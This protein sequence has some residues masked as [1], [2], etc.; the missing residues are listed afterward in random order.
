[1]PPARQHRARLVRFAIVA[2]IMIAQTFDAALTL[3]RE[4]VA[5]F[6]QNE[7]HF[8]SPKYSEYDVRREFIDRFWQALGWDVLHRAQPIPLERD[9]QVET[10]VQVEGRGKRADYAF[11]APNFRDVLFFVEAKKPSRNIENASDYFQTIRYGWHRQTPLAVLTD[12]E[13]FHVLDCRYKPDI[14]AVLQY[15]ALEKY[16]YTDYADAE[17]FRQI[18]HLFARAEAQGGALARYIE[19]LPKPKRGAQQ[20]GL[21]AKGAYQSIDEAFLQD[22]DAYREQL[23][24]AF[25][26][27]NPQLDGAQLTEITQRTLDRLVFMR[28]LEDKLIEPDELVEPLVESHKAWADFVALSQRLNRVYN[29]IIFKP[30][31]LLDAPGFK[32][33][34]RAFQ[35]IC[36]SLSHARSAYDFNLFPVHILG[37][38]YE[39]FLGKI[40]VATD[41]GATV[42]DKPEMRKADGVYYTPEYIVRYIVENTVGRLI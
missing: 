6:R 12:F 28:F 15:G 7:A 22:L 19:R 8:L 38:I 10:N 4:L 40:I 3:V 2:R 34:E 36:A 23:A 41:K 16:H 9:V 30:H 25:K 11:L 21:F 31:A 26:E 14:G 42:E 37:S 33:D 1:M 20:R 17:K 29:G 35:A 32:V 39:R 13:Q 24:R 18:Y 27:A 5:E